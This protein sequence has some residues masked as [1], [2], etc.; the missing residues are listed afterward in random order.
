MAK[1][2]RMNKATVI[3]AV[4]VLEA[5]KMMSVERCVGGNNTYR[6][7]DKDAWLPPEMLDSIRLKI[8]TGK[9]EVTVSTSAKEVTEVCKRGNATSTKEV[10]GEC[11]IGN[12]STSIEGSP[13][14]VTPSKVTPH[15]E[16]VENPSID[17][18]D[19]F[20]KDYPK[21]VGKGEARKAFVKKRC[22]PL[23]DTLL[24]AIKVQRESMAWNRDDGRYIPNPSTW[25]NQGRWEDELEPMSTANGPKRSNP[26]ADRIALERKRDE[27]KEEYIKLEP[28]YDWDRTPERMNRRK[29][30][31]IQI[32]N[33]EAQIAELLPNPVPA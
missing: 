16:G 19:L 5:V 29:D 3:R 6:L 30:L 33:I 1:I 27:L 32:E 21:K 4:R 15:C 31:R 22:A 26:V 9:K 25:L 11:N 24:A 17:P 7:T 14:K 13:L 10:T 28:Q 8:D 23:I 20:W 2:C 18:F 12:E